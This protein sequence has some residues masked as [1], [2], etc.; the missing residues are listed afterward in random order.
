MGTFIVG[1]TPAADRATRQAASQ[2]HLY[3]EARNVMRGLRNKAR[4][5][6]R[7]GS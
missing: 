1:L 6:V 2:M 4:R 7:R 5:L 3:R